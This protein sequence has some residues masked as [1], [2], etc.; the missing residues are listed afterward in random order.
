MW[1]DA[2]AMRAPLAHAPR[3]PRAAWA[4]AFAVV[5]TG[6]A[7]AVV[8]RLPPMH[9]RVGWQPSDASVPLGYQLSVFPAFGAFVGALAIDIVRGDARATWLPR[10]VLAATLG[11]LAVARIA[12]AL[13]LSGHALYLFGALAYEVTA[14]SDRGADSAVTLSLIAPALLVVA[15]CKL[16]VWADPLWFAVSALLGA[17]LG[18][19]LARAAR[20]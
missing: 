19:L 16:V 20:P 9:V 12:G 11:S 14:P 5:A 18:V 17:A 2:V 8:A 6:I 7:W 15:W 10:A 4:L 1:I 3:A 13:P